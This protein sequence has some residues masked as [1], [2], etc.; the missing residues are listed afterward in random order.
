VEGQHGVGHLMLST[1]ARACK[2]CFPI[3]YVFQNYSFPPPFF[4]LKKIP[5][6][7]RETQLWTSRT[8]N[9]L[10]PELWKLAEVTEQNV[11][12]YPKFR[13]VGNT[14]RYLRIF[15]VTILLR[16]RIEYDAVRS[17]EELLQEWKAKQKRTYD[18]WTD[19][20]V[21]YYDRTRTR[22]SQQNK[23][24]SMPW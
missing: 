21:S 23:Y 8:F 3:Q 1:R 4:F 15:N 20:K 5:S 6:Y 14:S 12:R 22:P 16:L 7:Q 19:T 17:D 10:P 9:D 24:N 11:L 18:S 2:N 13:P